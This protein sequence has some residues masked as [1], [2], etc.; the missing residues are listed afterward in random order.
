MGRVSLRLDATCRTAI[1]VDELAATVTETEIEILANFLL[2]KTDIK[3]RA[4][5]E[6]QLGLVGEKTE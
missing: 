5:A 4:R 2:Q 1:L 6:T 3:Q